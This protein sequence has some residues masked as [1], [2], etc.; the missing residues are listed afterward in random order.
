MQ[1]VCG[2]VWDVKPCIQLVGVFD[3]EKIANYTAFLDLKVRL[4]LL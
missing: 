2:V 3:P 4:F 1:H